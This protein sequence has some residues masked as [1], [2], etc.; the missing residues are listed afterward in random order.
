VLPT[1]KPLSLYQR[2]NSKQ[3]VETKVI[4]EKILSNMQRAQKSPKIFIKQ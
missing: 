2:F 1:K 3:V 4:Q